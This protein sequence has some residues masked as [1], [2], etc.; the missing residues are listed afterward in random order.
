MLGQ[1]IFIRT[2]NIYS[3]EN[4]GR[5]VHYL[6]VKQTINKEVLTLINMHGPNEGVAIFIKR[7]LTELQKRI[8]GNTIKA[9]DYNI[10]LLML[11]RST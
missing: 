2:N 9:Q 5:V 8:D 1:H 7:L 4:R 6:L 3:K 11:D 10:P